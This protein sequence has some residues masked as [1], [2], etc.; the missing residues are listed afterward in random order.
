MPLI[1]YHHFRDLGRLF[2]EGSMIRTPKMD[3]YEKDGNIVAEIELLGI[4]PKNIEVEVKDNVLKVEARTEKKKE[5][6]KK[7]FYHRE[8][9][10]GYYRR[11]IPLPAEVVSE[12]A[13]AD[14]GDDILKI[15]IP[16]AKIKR[17][18]EK[19]RRTKVKIKK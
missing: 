13:S 12:K 17:K 10:R 7:G 16:K 1:P 11:A 18:K 5:E 14:Y 15:V 4:D 6:K 8:L 3:I 9:S 2:G 19:V